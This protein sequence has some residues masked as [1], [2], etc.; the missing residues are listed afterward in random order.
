MVPELLLFLAFLGR[1]GKVM[2]STQEEVGGKVK[3]LRWNCTRG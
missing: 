1:R 2:V 3:S